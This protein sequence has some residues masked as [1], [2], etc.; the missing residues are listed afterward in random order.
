MEPARLLDTLRGLPG[1]TALMLFDARDGRVVAEQ[2]PALLTGVPGDT[3]RRCIAGLYADLQ[4]DGFPARD[5]LFHYAD[6]WV[7]TRYWDGLVLVVL[8]PQR[9]GHAAVRMASNLLVR[10]GSRASLM[11]AT[12]RAKQAPAPDDVAVMPAQRRV[13]R[14]QPY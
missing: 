13:Y 14:G 10:H 6:Y 12:T 11:E 2:L 3:A 7:M 4:R 9:T 8:A 5:L 1:I